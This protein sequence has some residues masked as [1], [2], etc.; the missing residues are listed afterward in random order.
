MLPR[1]HLTPHF[2]REM[3]SLEVFVKWKFSVNL[4]A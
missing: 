3:L 2:M 4:N 1:G